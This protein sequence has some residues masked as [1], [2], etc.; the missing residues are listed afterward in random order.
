MS[1]LS[2]RLQT[3]LVTAGSSFDVSVLLNKG[4]GALHDP[5]GYA[6]GGVTGYDVVVGDL[7]D[8]GKLDLTVTTTTSRIIGY[9][10]GY[11]GGSYPLAVAAYNAGPGAVRKYGNQIPPYRETQQYVVSV[12]HWYRLFKAAEQAQRP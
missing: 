12:L 5:V 9:Q 4:D 6:H 1:E 8:D 3:D 11:Y 2:D 10:Y 7:N